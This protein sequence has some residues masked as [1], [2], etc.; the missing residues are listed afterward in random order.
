[1]TLTRRQLTT[2]LLAQAGASLG[3]AS[4]PQT[5]LAQP[6]G[7]QRPVVICMSLEPNSLDPTTSPGAN[8][9][10]V[11]HYNLLEGLTKIEESGGTS[12]LLAESWTRSADGRSYSFQLRRGVSFHDGSPFDAE[13]VKFSFERARA[14]GSTN[15]ARKTLFDNI[16]TIT[17]PDPHTVVLNLHHADANLLFRLGENTA[18]ILHPK[19]AAQAST[20]PVGTGPY[21]FESWR[22][23]WGTTL[24]KFAQHRQAA[25]VQVPEVTFRY[26]NDPQEQA[27]AVLGGEVDMLFN[28]A[29]QNVARFRNNSH[30]QVMIGASNG[31]GML[32]VNH[33]RPPLDDV[34]VRRALTH[35]IDREAFIRKVLD[36]R[37]RAIGSHYSPTEPG[38]VH[39]AGLYPYNPDKARQ[40]LREAGVRQPLSL[41][42]TLPPNPYARSQ[43][44]FFVEALGQIGIDL[45]LEE[46][47]WPQWL[48][49]TFKGQFDLS[50]INH[51]EPLDYPIYGDP[52]YYFGYD[53][54][55][56]RE[57][58]ARHASSQHPRERQVLQSDIQR[59]LAND[60]VNVWI[61]A[62]QV[63]AVSRKGLKGWW[64]NYP[65]FAHDIAAL[66][67][68]T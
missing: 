44:E 39:L 30:Y 47:S 15:K 62:S 40:L 24:V 56:F 20:A 34:R 21:C 26:I 7:R 8:I 60:A 65:I 18:V 9:G 25:Q 17:T 45:R 59:H 22:K 57:L 49:G 53:S 29:S 58:L 3:W 38:Y 19:T 66:W 12:P 10:E 23:G 46:V 50:L 2:A 48:E 54:P 4:S 35:A 61:F 64:M 55:A 36:G 11:V 28:I 37:G 33:R 1:M 32:A 31:K 13:S 14:P 27:A 43:P 41:S 16:A 63:S 67:W 52:G 51:V 68:E 6:L 42:L 5:G